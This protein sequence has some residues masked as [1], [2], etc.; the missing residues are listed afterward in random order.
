MLPRSKNARP[1]GSKRA[2][3]R[4]LQ[5]VPIEGDRAV[6]VGHAL[7]DL[8]QAVRTR[9]DAH[10]V[11]VQLQ[12][13]PAPLTMPN[14]P[15]RP[16]EAVH[17][18]LVDFVR[19]RDA[20][21]DD[22]SALRGPSRSTRGWRRSPT[23]IGLSLT[24]IGCFPHAR[25]DVGDGRDRLV[26]RRRASRRSRRASSPARARPSASRSPGRGGRWPPRARRSGDPDVFDAR[27]V[28][29]GAARSRSRNTRILR[30]SR[31]GTASITRSV[32]AASSNVGGERDARERGVG[33]GTREL[34]ARSPRCRARSDRW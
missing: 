29:G 23:A 7:G 14:G 26:A 21:V 11:R 9:L 13:E 25:R 18:Q 28:V 15:A 34:A 19:G 3:E 4:E 1:G 5:H 30:S 17:H 2:D 12:P 16:A 24:T 10:D 33:F 8:M 32:A 6:E 22:A 31:S 20:F 27:I